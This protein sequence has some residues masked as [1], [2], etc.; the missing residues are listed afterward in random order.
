MKYCTRKW[1]SPSTH[2]SAYVMCYYNPDC[3]NSTYRLF[4]RIADC[5][6]S[7]V[8]DDDPKKIKTTIKVLNK[9]IDLAEGRIHKFTI[10]SGG[11]FVFEFHNRQITNLNGAVIGSVFSVSRYY[12]KR[13][14]KKYGFKSDNQKSLLHLHCDDETCSEK[15]WFRKM[16]VLATEL[17]KFV[18]FLE[19]INR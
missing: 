9:I 13:I 3:I 14:I 11:P 17:K 1:L 2:S 10:A 8:Y 7:F 12:P 16:N 6:R 5:E 4:I 19:G 15:E 18:T